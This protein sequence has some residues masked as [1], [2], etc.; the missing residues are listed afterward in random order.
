MQRVSTI[1][2]AGLQQQWVTS[3]RHGEWIETEHRPRLKPAAGKVA[4]CHQHCPVQRSPL[5]VAALS[6]LVIVLT[7]HKSVRHEHPVAEHTAARRQCYR[8]GNPGRARSHSLHADSQRSD[9][10]VFC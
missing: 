6:T 1:G 8:I 5:L 9:H 10:H 2:F 3:L 4:R 7:E